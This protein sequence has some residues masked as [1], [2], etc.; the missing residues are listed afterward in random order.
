MSARERDKEKKERG[1]RNSLHEAGEIWTTQE[2]GIR[3]KKKE[4]KMLERR[5][6]KS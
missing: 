6:E 4:C 2:A 1:K 3:K 5:E